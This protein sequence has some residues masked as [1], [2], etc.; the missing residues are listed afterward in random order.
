MLPSEASSKKKQ[1]LRL[2]RNDNDK[3]ESPRMTSIKKTQFFGLKWSDKE[4]SES[5][6]LTATKEREKKLK[7]GEES[8]LLLPCSSDLPVLSFANKLVSCRSKLCAHKRSNLPSL[9]SRAEIR[10]EAEISVKNNNDGFLLR[11]KGK[12]ISMAPAVN[13]KEEEK[14][15]RRNGNTLRLDVPGKGNDGHAA[16]GDQTN[17]LTF[18]L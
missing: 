6:I 15:G 4:K 2:E 7:R 18:N 10:G 16:E 3:S 5:P 11:R 9:R 1:F 14:S 13:T 8:V 17:S 12:G